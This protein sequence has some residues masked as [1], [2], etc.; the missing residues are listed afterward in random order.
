MPCLGCCRVSD[1]LNN[2]LSRTPDH[3]SINHISKSENTR[4]GTTC[5]VSCAFKR[6]FDMRSNS[7][8]VSI[9]AVSLQKESKV[10]SGP[11]IAVPAL[12]ITYGYCYCYVTGTSTVLLVLL[13]SSGTSTTLPPIRHYYY[14]CY[15]S[16]ESHDDSHPVSR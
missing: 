9:C 14:H 16:H 10:R 8:T 12:M 11:G 7:K 4:R 1:S 2:V 13:A 5:T 3:P 6:Q 15:H